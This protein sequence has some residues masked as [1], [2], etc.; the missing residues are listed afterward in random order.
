MQAHLVPAGSVI[1][2]LHLPPLPGSPRPGPSAQ[3]LLDHALRDAEALAEGG[4]AGCIIEN[5][6]DAPFTPDRVEPHVVAH[7]SVIAAEVKR[8]FG[9]RLCLGINVLRN[10]ALDAVGV[11]SAVGADFVRVNVLSGAMVTD[12]G[13]IQG[14]ARELALYRRRLGIDCAVAADILVKH[15]S[16]LGELS[17]E[18]AAR[19]G[20]HRG[21]ADVLI[22]T[23]A[24]TGLPADPA[25]LEAVR[26]AVPEAP[27]WLGSGL[28]PDNAALYRPHCHAAI[29][30]TW[31]HRQAQLHQ[32]LELERVQRVVEAF[33]A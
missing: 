22:I 31:L 33:G 8:R 1:G 30:G 17:I 32:P 13:I 23:G 18:Q 21:G 27:V 15:A 19:D 9:E 2:V 12:Q 24:G 4:A 6:G 25:R 10:A 5:L 26:A 7:M 20:F 29:V 14:Q 16:P 28:N 3:A 11:A